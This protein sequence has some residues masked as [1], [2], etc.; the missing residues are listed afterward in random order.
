MIICGIAGA[1]VTVVLPLGQLSHAHVASGPHQFEEN[2]EVE[3][4]Q[5]ITVKCVNDSLGEGWAETEQEKSRCVF[6]ANLWLTDMWLPEIKPMPSEWSKAGI[7]VASELAKGS[8][9]IG[10]AY[11]L[12]PTLEQKGAPNPGSYHISG[13]RYSPKEVLALALI[14]PWIG[15]GRVFNKGRGGWQ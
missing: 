14:Q 15:W 5:Y 10:F 12:A 2:T 11:G 8:V 13:R 7:L 4:L 9:Y 3:I 1:A 6:M